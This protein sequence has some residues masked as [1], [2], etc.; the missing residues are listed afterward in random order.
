MLIFA[1][2]F[3]LSIVV[4]AIQ[5]FRGK[6]LWDTPALPVLIVLHFAWVVPFTLVIAAKAAV[7]VIPIFLVLGLALCL[8]IGIAWLMGRIKGHP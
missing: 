7:V 5:M 8:V 1:A 6:E 4:G 3:S 2:S